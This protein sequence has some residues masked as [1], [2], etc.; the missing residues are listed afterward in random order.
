VREYAVPTGAV[1][2]VA[3]HGRTVPNLRQLLGNYYEAL[4]TAAKARHAGHSH[5]AVRQDDLVV[6]SRGHMRSFSGIAYLPSQLPSGLK[7]QDIQ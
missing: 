1:V 3:W 7:E 5:L 4:L 2:A 6:M